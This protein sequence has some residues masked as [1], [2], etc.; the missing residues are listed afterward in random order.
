MGA[1]SI[2]RDRNYHNQPQ[3]FLLL[4]SSATSINFAAQ[5]KVLELIFN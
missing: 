2:F 3:V 4:R 5:S 1:V